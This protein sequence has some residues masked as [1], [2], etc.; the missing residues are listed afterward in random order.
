MSFLSKLFGKK[1]VIENPIEVFDETNEI[2][3]AND[4][5]FLNE[6][7]AICLNIIGTDKWSKEKGIFMHKKCFRQKKREMLKQQ[8]NGERVNA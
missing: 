6:Q 8:F 4:R 3:I 1:K 5:D 7:C 2:Q